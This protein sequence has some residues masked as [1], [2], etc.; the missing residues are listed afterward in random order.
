V[1]HFLLVKAPPRVRI[2]PSYARHR[3]LRMG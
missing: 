2:K 3:H 1:E